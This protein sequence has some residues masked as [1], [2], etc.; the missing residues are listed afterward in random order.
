MKKRILSN[1]PHF[2]TVEEV[3][4]YYNIPIDE[5][6]KSE[7]S[8]NYISF[9]EFCEYY[10]ITEWREIDED[11]NVVYTESLKGTI[12]KKIRER[13]DEKEIRKEWNNIRGRSTSKIYHSAKVKDSD[14]DKIK[15]WMDGMKSAKTFDAYYKHFKKLCDFCF[16]NPKN[17]D[18]NRYII[19]KGKKPDNNFVL[20]Q[21]VNTRHEVTVPAGCSIYHYSPKKLNKLQP[22]WMGR[23]GHLYCYPRL[24][25]TLKKNMGIMHADM[26]PGTSR[27]LYEVTEPIKKV[28]VDPMVNRF[29]P[30]QSA[31]SAMAVYIESRFPIS[32]KMISSPN[33]PVKESADSDEVMFESLDAFMNYYGLTF[34]DEPVEE[35]FNFNIGRV[36]RTITSNMKA[37]SEWEGLVSK[38]KNA[39][40]T[41][42]ATRFDIKK[43]K[44]HYS[45][46]KSADSFRQYKPSHK[47][48]CK[49]FSLNAEETVIHD[50]YVNDNNT[51]TI[52]YASGKRKIIVPNDVTL[53]YKGSEKHGQEVDPKFKASGKFY[54]SNRIYFTLKNNTM[55][56]ANS[57][58]YTP[59]EDIK[60]VYIDPSNPSYKSGSVYVETDHPMKIISLKQKIKGIIS[61]GKSFLIKK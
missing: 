33:K 49:K 34:A 25:C 27:Y 2:D 53:I 19:R 21:Y 8:E 55:G 5:D 39:K 36:T 52:S 20:L 59:E 43:M 41:R 29:N 58:S 18:I 56:M 4:E 35:A 31:H 16:I 54:P 13:K 22:Q 44:E 30:F 7:P 57:N 28:F 26:K 45:N 14:F 61:S 32:C 3:C 60:T 38:F 1:E 50:M 37:Q 40:E 15:G 11:G 51:V 47:Y 46:M 9:E 24:Y 10:G 12:G 17:A 48:L 42:R 23:I 6:V